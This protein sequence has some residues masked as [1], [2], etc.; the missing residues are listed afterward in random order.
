MFVRPNLIVP[1]YDVSMPCSYSYL[2]FSSMV[3]MHGIM[4]HNQEFRHKDSHFFG[5]FQ[6]CVKNLG[7]LFYN[8]QKIIIFAPDILCQNEI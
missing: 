8:S 7:N 3:V 5:N 6:N 4:C 2:S 1:S